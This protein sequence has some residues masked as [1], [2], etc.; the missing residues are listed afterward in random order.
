MPG[1][2]G[3]RLVRAQAPS[4]APS[5]AAATPRFEIA[6]IKPNPGCEGVSSGPRLGINLSPG[7]LSI[8]CQAVDFLVRQ[9]YLA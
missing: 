6:S 4:L 1:A 9:A 7:R 2:N 8:K 3:L 5:S